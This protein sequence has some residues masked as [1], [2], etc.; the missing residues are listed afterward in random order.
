MGCRGAAS[1]QRNGFRGLPLLA[2]AKV[3]AVGLALS[4]CASMSEK[5]A[6][7][8]SQ[9]PEI[10]LPANAPARPAQQMAYP[11]VHDIPPPRTAAVLTDVEQQKM[12]SDLVA[13][14]NQLQGAAGTAAAKKTVENKKTVEKSPGKKTPSTKVRAAKAQTSK[15]Q[16][17]TD[18]TTEAAPIS[19]SSSR[20]IY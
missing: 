12:E 17:Y 19:T 11:A 5:F 15:A 8:A 10:G 3:M 4:G 13:A 16:G 1:Q 7:T 18:E 6:E 9:M 14:R 20:T 2:A